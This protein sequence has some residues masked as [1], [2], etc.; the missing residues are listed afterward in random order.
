MWA[1]RVPI[2]SLE[3]TGQYFMSTQNYNLVYF[4]KGEYNQ[5]LQSPHIEGTWSE[6]SLLK[7]SGYGRRDFE[8]THIVFLCLGRKPKFC[9]FLEHRESSTTMIFHLLVKLDDFV[10]ND[11]IS[12]GI[13]KLLEVASQDHLL[14]FFCGSEGTCLLHQELIINRTWNFEKKHGNMKANKAIKCL[15]SKF[16]LLVPWGDHA[17]SVIT[18]YASREFKTYFRN[19]KIDIKSK[20]VRDKLNNTNL[21]NARVLLQ[22]QESRILS[23]RKQLEENEAKQLILPYQYEDLTYDLNHEVYT[24]RITEQKIKEHEQKLVLE[25][26]TKKSKHK[27]FEQSSKRSRSKRYSQI[28]KHRGIDENDITSNMENMRITNGTSL[29]IID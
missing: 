3:V 18:F 26:R 19:K 4:T 15:E 1:R 9:L 13:G 20:Q 21:K 28:M 17:R 2:S 27:R 7:A 14:V 25:Q 12:Q 5:P 10:N 6:E 11:E 29:E 24:H 16:N 23:L 8:Y 22:S